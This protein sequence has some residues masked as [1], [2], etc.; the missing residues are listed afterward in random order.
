MVASDGRG[1]RGRSGPE[2][3]ELV[4][5]STTQAVNALLEGDV[6]DG[7]RAGA[8]PP[9][10]PAQGAAKRT[11]LDGLELAPGKP[12]PV[13]AEFLDI[14]DGFDESAID[15]ALD[16]LVAGGPRSICVAEAF[17]PDDGSDERRAVPAAIG[18]GLPS[19]G[20][21]EMTGLYGL[22]LRTVT[23]RSTRRSCRSPLQTAQH[24]EDG[25]VAGRHH[26][27]R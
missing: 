15:A 2:R 25:V 19:C 1:R 8:R 23:R 11:R 6:G 16:R 20:S 4:T 18:R 10:R 21:A 24:V 12:L 22:E 5:H 9:A 13:V 26:A 27:H 14:T 3:V 17:A 7:R